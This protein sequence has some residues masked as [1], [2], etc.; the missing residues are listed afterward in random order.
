MEHLFGNV[1]SKDANVCHG[2]YLLSVNGG[3]GKEAGPLH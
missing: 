3:S 1:N 2:A